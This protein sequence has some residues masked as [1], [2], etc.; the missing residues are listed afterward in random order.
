MLQVHDN[1]NDEAMSDD[2]DDDDN[3]SIINIFTQQVKHSG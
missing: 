2:D 3:R 1:P